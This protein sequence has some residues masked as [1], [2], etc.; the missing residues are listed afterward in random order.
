MKK[1]RIDELV[2]VWQQVEYVFADD[3]DLSSKKKI[4]NAIKNCEYWDCE[5]KDTYWDT[6]GHLQ[7]DETTIK[8]L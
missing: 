3:V 2:K 6:E 4:M 1:I 8:E 5:A 7:W